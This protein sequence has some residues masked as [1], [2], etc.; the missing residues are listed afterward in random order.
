MGIY[1]RKKKTGKSY[2]PY[3]VQYPYK[4]DLSNGKIVYKTETVGYKKREANNLFAE[5]ML[6]WKNKK[7]LGFEARED[8]SFREGDNQI[9]Q[10]VLQQ[11]TILM[12]HLC[13]TGSQQGLISLVYHI[14]NGS[15][16]QV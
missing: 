13:T 15:F 1:R 2:G 14:V 4:R 3:I 7:D 9:C 16:Y 11:S 8:I 5:K 10:D 12:R 6:E